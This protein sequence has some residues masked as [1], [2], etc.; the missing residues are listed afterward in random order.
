MSDGES[1]ASSVVSERSV[2]ASNPSESDKT[3]IR[4]KFTLSG[5][6]TF[7]V[8]HPEQRSDPALL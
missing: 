3:G 5:D 2:D 7:K 8:M 1:V 4:V 6:G